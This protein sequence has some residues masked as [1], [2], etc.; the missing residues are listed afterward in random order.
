M[1]EEIGPGFGISV[2]LGFRAFR[3]IGFEFFK[4]FGKGLL[5][6]GFHW[7]IGSI[8]QR[9]SFFFLLHNLFDL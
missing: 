5:T 7:M 3:F 8:I 2:G 1:T 6:F 4:G 9:L